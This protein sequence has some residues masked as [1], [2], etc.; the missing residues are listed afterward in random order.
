MIVYILISVILVSLVSFVGVLFIALKEKTLNRLLN[1]LVSFA[2]GALLG[3]AF[4]HLLP[5][6]VENL[7]EKSF[8]LVIVAF[9]TFFILERIFRWRHCHLGH[10]S[11]HSFGYLN[12]LGD[13]LHNFVDGAVIAAAFLTD[14]SL[15]ISTTL[16]VVLHEVPQEVGDF[17]I[18]LYGG[19]EKKKALLFNFTSA[20]TAIFGALATYFFA[21]QISD[22]IPLLLPFAA[23]GFIYIAATDIIPELHKKE[24]LRQSL[25]EFF[26]ILLGIAL[27]GVL[28]NL[29]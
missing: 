3:G 7:G 22:L 21:Q 15:G 18:L 16:A 28:K 26:L 4:L 20:A 25:L 23:G 8:S 19:I 11:T 6:S 1:F 13:G 10:C 27:M 14:I 2:C 9:L 29:L 5:E 12:L 17:S 24:N